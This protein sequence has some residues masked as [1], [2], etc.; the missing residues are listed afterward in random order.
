LDRTHHLLQK[1]AM[2]PSIRLLANPDAQGYCMK[3]QEQTFREE[4]YH[5]PAKQEVHAYFV[6][7]RSVDTLHQPCTNYNFQRPMGPH[8]H[9]G[10][11]RLAATVA[12]C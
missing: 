8:R 12:S 7:K 1:S 2:G 6:L 3:R 4:K 5:A 9:I 11:A 10:V